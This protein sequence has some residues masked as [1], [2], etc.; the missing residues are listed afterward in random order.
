MPITYIVGPAC[1]SKTT[2][3]E[4]YRKEVP[5]RVKV[6]QVGSRGLPRTYFQSAKK[7]AMSFFAEYPTLETMRDLKELA[8]ACP[9]VQ[10]VVTIEDD[11]SLSKVISKSVHPE[12]GF[13]QTYEDVRRP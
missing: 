11:G 7:E 9:E 13:Q 5:E 2:L 6:I 4:A 3:L 8:K 1:S 12:E 10:I